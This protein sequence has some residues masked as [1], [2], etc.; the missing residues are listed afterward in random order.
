MQQ[1]NLS[2]MWVI[3]E[4]GK[5]GAKEVNGYPSGKSYILKREF[6]QDIVQM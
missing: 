5:I 4:K 2:M 1:S 3:C 6:S